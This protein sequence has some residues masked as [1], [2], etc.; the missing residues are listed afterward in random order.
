MSGIAPKQ[1][2]FKFNI[3]P[4]RQKSIAENAPIP[5]ANG[6][7]CLITPKHNGKFSTELYVSVMIRKD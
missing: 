1:K 4:H 6:T 3:A 2:A 5:L 7:L